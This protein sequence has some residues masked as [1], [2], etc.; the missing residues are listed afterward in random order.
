MT[1]TEFKCSLCGGKLTS[2]TGAELNQSVG[3]IYLRCENLCDPQCHE[4]VYG[5][6]DNEKEAYAALIQKFQ[7]PKD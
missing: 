1:I 5:H 4:N 6:G 2:Y 7:K 3:G